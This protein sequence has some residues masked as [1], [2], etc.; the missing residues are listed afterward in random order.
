LNP[1]PKSMR[2]RK[3]Y[4]LFKSDFTGSKKDFFDA[5][6]FS[7]LNEFNSI[8]LAKADLRLIFLE[9]GFGL[10]RVNFA[11]IENAKKML[12]ELKIKGKKA[13]NEFISLHGT[14]KSAKKIEKEKH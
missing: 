3:R 13:K 8:G 7:F 10:L 12:S 1:L 11:W 2:E 6:Q 14:I 4:V 9:K 5:V